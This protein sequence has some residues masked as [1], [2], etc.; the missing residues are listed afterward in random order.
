L[1]H[2]DGGRDVRKIAVGIAEELEKLLKKNKYSLTNT[3]Q[4]EYRIF[5]EQKQKE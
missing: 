5:L 2:P 1:F 3:I 4:V